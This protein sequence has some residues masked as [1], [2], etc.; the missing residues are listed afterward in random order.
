MVGLRSVRNPRWARF[1]F[2]SC[3]RGLILRGTAVIAAGLFLM[4]GPLPA[5]AQSE[6]LDTSGTGGLDTPGSVEGDAEVVLA[7]SS[8]PAELTLEGMVLTRQG[9]PD[10]PFTG[11]GIASN[12][13]TPFIPFTASELDGIDVVPAM[14]G[15]LRGELFEQAVEFGASSW[16]PSSWRPRRSIS[17]PRTTIRPTPT[18]P[19]TWRTIPAQTSTQ[20]IPRTST[21]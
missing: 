10:I 15:A 17:A 13:P 18:P 3:V 11:R 5:Y 14:R 21:R 9:L 6:D 2:G 16:R 20:R 1:G 12:N 8:K 4:A 19:F 7:V